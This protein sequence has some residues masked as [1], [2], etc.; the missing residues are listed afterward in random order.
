LFKQLQVSIQIIFYNLKR[1]YF[2]HLVLS[3]STLSLIKHIIVKKVT[4]ILFFFVHVIFLRD[5]IFNNN[6]NSIN[7]FK[8]FVYFWSIELGNPVF[9]MMSL[10]TLSNLE[11]L[12]RVLLFEFN[13]LAISAHYQL[14]IKT[15]N[16]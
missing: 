3:S 9:N 2:S 5:H 1:N 4:K 7:Y 6:N 8:S 15:K 14:T 10:Q 16:V 11:V 13:Q 12:G